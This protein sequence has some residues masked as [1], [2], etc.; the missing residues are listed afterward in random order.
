MGVSVKL[1][2]KKRGQVKNKTFFHFLFKKLDHE[3]N[4]SADSRFSGDL[5]LESCV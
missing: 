2:E 3:L 4:L 1:S 5:T